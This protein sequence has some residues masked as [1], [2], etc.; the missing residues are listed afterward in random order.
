MSWKW[1]DTMKFKKG[2]RVKF[3]KNTLG[4]HSEAPIGSEGE[5]KEVFEEEHE[6][7]VG[8]SFFDYE[9]I[10][11]EDELELVQEN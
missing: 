1:L 11:H 4:E 3:V 8:F 9:N 2:D 5:I 10:Y 6:Y 7:S